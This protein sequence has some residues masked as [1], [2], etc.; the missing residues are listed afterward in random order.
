MM[1]IEATPAGNLNSHSDLENISTKKKNKRTRRLSISKI[2]SR[3]GTEKQSEEDSSDHSSAYSTFSLKLRD[4][5]RSDTSQQSYDTCIEENTKDDD[6]LPMENPCLKEIDVDSLKDF[7]KKFEDLTIQDIQKND[8]DVEKKNGSIHAKGKNDHADGDS[9][10]EFKSVVRVLQ[11]PL[12]KDTYDWIKSLSYLQ[13]IRLT[14]ESALQRIQP[15]LAMGSTT[16][17]DAGYKETIVEKIMK[18]SATV[19]FAA[20]KI[21]DLLESK[22]FNPL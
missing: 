20:L 7:A 10:F 19:D 8:L 15:V 18:V 21:L 4:R 2:F 1:E 5:R 14:S 13:A 6:Y 9:A 12:V 3:I 16:L 22:W 11:F 17:D